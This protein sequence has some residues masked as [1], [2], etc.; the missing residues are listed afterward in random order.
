MFSTTHE[1]YRGYVFLPLQNASGWW[2][3]VWDQHGQFIAVTPGVVPTMGEAE[4]AA[5]GLIDNFFTETPN[6]RFLMTVSPVFHPKRIR[7]PSRASYD[8]YM[9]LHAGF[10]RFAHYATNLDSG[11]PILTF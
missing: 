5:R 9:K 6:E 2:A 11:L 10:F 1:K 3:E 4:S 8:A 7:F